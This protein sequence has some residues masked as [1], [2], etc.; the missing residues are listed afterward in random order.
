MNVT[1]NN[2]KQ[3]FKTNRPSQAT[4]KNVDDFSN[5]QGSCVDDVF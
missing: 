3:C 5:L 4:P 2:L 1:L